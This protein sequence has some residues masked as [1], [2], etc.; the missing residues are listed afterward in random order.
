MIDIDKANCQILLV[1]DE[2]HVIEVTKKFLEK[3]G[4]DNF[5]AVQD[6]RLAIP[7][8]KDKDI[9]LIILDL[10]MPNIT[11]TELQAVLIEEFA[12]IPIIIMTGSENLSDA[13]NCMDGVYD[14]LI[15]PVGMERL[16][17]AVGKALKY[18]MLQKQFASLSDSIF[19]DHLENPHAFRKIVTRDNKMRAIF[20]YVEQTSKS[21]LPILIT[22]ESGVGK[23]LFA[24]CIHELSG[25]KGKFVEVNTAGLDDH[26]FSD[27][28]FGHRKGAYTDAGNAREGLI[29]KANGGSLFLDE[30]G[31]LSNLSQIKLLRYLQEQ[32]FYPLG[33]D[34]LVDSDARILCSTNKNLEALVSRGSFRKDL[35]YRL[36]THRIHIPPLRSRPEDIPLL[37]NYF[38]KAAAD[39]MGKQK[40]VPSSE[41]MILLPKLAFPGNV[42]ELK[43]MVTDAVARH[44]PGSGLLT[45]QHFQTINTYKLSNNDVISLPTTKRYRFNA[46]FER[47]PTMKEIEE[48]MI[49]KAMEITKGNQTAAAKL[50]GVTRQAL[51]KRK[52]SGKKKV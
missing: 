26:M 35:Y 18:N 4:Y 11:G 39:L 29:C 6:S 3:G 45:I 10:M 44:V 12:Q 22:G 49:R 36:C 19:T 17:S 37:L 15:K 25:L 41:L 32:N 48:Y 13:I 38:I 52:R 21:N 27:T 7:L 2:P 46:G 1:D 34:I 23:E 43:A 47:F 24:H 30:I 20:Q 14:Y 28:L 33:S 40:P 16:L 31:D 42:R 9:S 51:G 5:Y 50:L 8:L